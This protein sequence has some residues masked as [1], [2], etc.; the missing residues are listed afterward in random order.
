MKNDNEIN[1]DVDVKSEEMSNSKDRRDNN[2][3]DFKKPTNWFESVKCACDGVIYAF[4][5]EGHVRVH[6]LLAVGALIVSLLL[7]LT[8]TEFMLFALAVL[9]LLVAEMFNTAIEDLANLVERRYNEKIKRVKDVSAGGVL[10]SSFAFL[11]MGYVIITK[12][13]SEPFTFAVGAL[14]ADYGMVVGVTLLVVL[15]LVVAAK[16]IWSSSD[17][18][19]KK[20]SPSVHAAIS[21][22][23]WTAITLITMNVLVSFLAF[24]MAL[25]VSH[26]RLLLE[27]NTVL[28]VFTGALAGIGITVIVFYLFGASF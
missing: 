26:S 9:M 5:T 20:A 4:R 21:F 11:I 1:N 19:F 10:I 27:E 25:M 6:Y 16:S 15:I 22:S 24:I 3:N 14:K 18:G 13:L 17:N 7:D 8:Y 23:T 28:N 12:Y 2:N